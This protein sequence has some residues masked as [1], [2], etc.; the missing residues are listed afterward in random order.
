[1]EYNDFKTPDEYSLHK[2]EQEYA[3]AQPP[4]KVLANTNSC[5][6]CNDKNWIFNNINWSRDNN[7]LRLLGVRS[8]NEC[9]ANFIRRLQDLSAQDYQ[10][11]RNLYP[12]QISARVNPSMENSI[13]IGFNMTLREYVREELDLLTAL[14]NIEF[15][16]EDA[17]NRTIIYNIMQRRLDA[18]STL[19]GQFSTGFFG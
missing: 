14:N 4:I 10:D 3:R 6:Q 17:T 18:L 15:L 8:P 16:E 9:V 19:V 7:L 13:P 11:L 5:M 1:M 12:E 2:M